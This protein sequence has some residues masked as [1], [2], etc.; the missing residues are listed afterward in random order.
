VAS[1]PG[2]SAA[3]S[4]ALGGPEWLRSFRASAFERWEGADLPSEAEETWRYSRIGELDIER[5]APATAVTPDRDTARLPADRTFAHTSGM[6]WT[7][8]GRVFASDVSEE[9]AAKDVAVTS[10]RTALASNAPWA[11][12]ASQE[13]SDLLGTVAVAEDAFDHLAGAFVEDVI[14]IS[15]PE[16]VVVEHPVVVVHWDDAAPSR[17]QVS[18][19]RTLV[20]A[21]PGSTLQVVEIAASAGGAAGSMSTLSLPVTEVVVGDGAQVAYAY[22]QDLSAADWQLCRQAFSAGK[23][24]SLISFTAAFGG[25]YCRVRTD[26]Y[27]VGSGAK[28]RLLAAYFGT[29]TQMH[30]FRTLQDHQAPSTRSNLLF[31]GGVGG[32]ARSVYSGLIRIR[33]G[34]YR[35]EAFQENRNLVLSPGAHADSVPNLDIAENDVRCSHASAVGPVDPDQLYYLESRGIEPEVAESLVVEGFFEDIVARAPEMPVLAELVGGHVR[36]KLAELE[37]GS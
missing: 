20:V 8:G 33:K 30:D 11:L 22:L 37:A 7:Q 21:A 25:D 13:A 31:K 10:V 16:S 35:S 14:V 12:R 34:A 5:W 3:A 27:S 32:T 9:A 28:T 6:V 15:V 4:A 26:S 2:F 24:S 19:P 36:S 18:F 1:A 23:D 29:G 17:S